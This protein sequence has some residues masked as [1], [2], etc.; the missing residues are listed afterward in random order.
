LDFD[1][2]EFIHDAA[3]NKEQV[4]CI[5]KLL[6]HSHTEDWT[7]NNYNDLESTQWAALHCMTAFQMMIISAPFGGEMMEFKM[8]YHSLWDWACNLLKDSGVG[9]YFVFDAQHLSKFNGTSS[10]HFINEP[11]TA[12]KFWDVQVCH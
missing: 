12:N 5:L 10:V 4:N 3:L 6:K 8:Y 11:W 7:L 9:P 2:S 1:L